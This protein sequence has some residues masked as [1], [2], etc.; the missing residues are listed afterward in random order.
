MAIEPVNRQ[1]GASPQSGFSRS[2]HNTLGN[3]GKRNTR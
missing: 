3:H 2:I 1:L